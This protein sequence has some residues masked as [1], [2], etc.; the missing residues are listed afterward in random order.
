MH[1]EVYI[2][3]FY[4]V[5]QFLIYKRGEISNNKRVKINKYRIR[6]VVQSI[7][8][9]IK[10]YKRNL[11]KVLDILILVDEIKFFGIIR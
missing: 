1:T 11:R 7:T 6:V 4:I 8:R 3:I 2:Y 9:K 10:S 5:I